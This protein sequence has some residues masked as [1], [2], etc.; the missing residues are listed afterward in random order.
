[1]DDIQVSIETDIKQVNRQDWDRL[2]NGDCFYLSYNWLS[3]VADQA[4]PGTEY[5]L[6]L[7]GETLVGALPLHQTGSPQ[8]SLYAPERLGALVG[9]PGRYL[10]AGGSRGYSNRL[11]LHPDLT[12]TTQKAVTAELIET[13]L[14]RAAASAMNGIIFPYASST[15]MRQIGETTTALA[16]LDTVEAEITCDPPGLVE[17]LASV[18]AHR[19]RRIRREIAA[20]ERAGWRSSVERLADCWRE[21]AALIA[22]VQ[23]KY[24]EDETAEEVAVSLCRQADALVGHD[25]V[26]CCRDEAGRLAGVALMY[27]WRNSLY[28]RA[29]G[30]DYPRLRGACEYFAVTYY[31]PLEYM[32]SH[33]LVRLHLGIDAW[34]AKA[35][36][37]ATLRPLWAVAVRLGEQGGPPGLRVYDPAAVARWRDQIDRYG[38]RTPP[39]DWSTGGIAAK[40]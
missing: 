35:L 31:L 14:R 21:A 22:N 23:R 29:V 15:M 25:V 16:G 33:G 6:A 38:G 36:R 39:G 19:R 26:F 13:A 27:R 28:A 8:S 20:F 18:S 17:H 1:M 4:G 9:R 40:P 12:E 11:L 7:R 5:V 24:G 30:F 3:M 2:A 34:T 37:G 10:L 32:A